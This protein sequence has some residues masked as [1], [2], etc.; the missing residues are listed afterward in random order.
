MADFK[1]YFSSHAP[2]YARFRPRYPAE[3]FSFAASI[4]DRHQR[5]WDAGTGNGQAAV[6]LAQ[7]FDE[8]IATDASEEQIRHAEPH[9]RVRYIVAR[10]EDAPLENASVDLIL[11]AQAAH[12]FDLPKF[13]AE[14]RRIGR[15][16]SVILLVTYG[17]TEIDEAIDPFVYSYANQAVGAYWPPERAHVDSGY[18]T[19]PFPFAEIPAPELAIEEEWTADQF[20]AYLGTWSATQNFIRSHDQDPRELVRASIEERWG[21]GVRVVRWPLRM[22]VGR[23]ERASGRPD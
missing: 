2:D 1:D 20:I 23:I 10:A 11:A 5:A 6:A 17:L 9:D 14:V 15:D 13:Y 19:L 21:D 16:G 22:R 7:H 18:L 4:I 8:V 3:L 12:W